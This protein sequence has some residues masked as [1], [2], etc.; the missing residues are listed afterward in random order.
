MYEICVRGRLS[1]RLEYALEG[2]QLEAGR[3][4]TVFIGEIRDQSQLYGLLDR[5]RDLGLE[6]IGV[7]PSIRHPA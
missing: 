2:M 3:A 5:V 4:E 1:E 6:L 7:Q